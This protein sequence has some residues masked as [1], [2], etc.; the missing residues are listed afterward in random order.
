MFFILVETEH[1]EECFVNSSFEVLSA[2]RRMSPLELTSSWAEYLYLQKMR[3][4][5][6][7]NS[8]VDVE[9]LQLDAQVCRAVSSFTVAWQA[10][11][12]ADFSCLAR[13]AYVRAWALPAWGAWAH[14]SHMG[15]RHCYDLCISTDALSKLYS[16]T[17]DK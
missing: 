7:R 14:A 10:A 4:R 11:L 13:L 1:L 3:I 12:F 5:H 15:D 2:S 9:S 16:G 6:S 8:V 17:F